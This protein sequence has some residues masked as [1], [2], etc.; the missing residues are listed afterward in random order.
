MPL[1]KEN[2]RYTYADYST[3][4]DGGRWELIDGIA[5]AMAP[6]PG[7]GHQ[8]ISVRLSWQ[9]QSFLN[10]KPCRLFTAPFDVRLNATDEDDTVVLPD[11]SVICDR[12][13]ID[14]KGCKGAPD[15][16][17]EILSPSSARMDKLLKYNK[18]QQAGVREYWIID[19][20]T[21]TVQ[22]SILENGRY[23]T[24]VY[25]EEDAAPVAVLPGCE[26]ILK[27]VFAEL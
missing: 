24:T 12:N 2:E 14:D 3:W 15:L 27:D 17:I 16:V 22:V 5:Y 6:A 25:G 23:Y 11:L 13:K 9:L 1:T 21:A 20:D 18:Y 4:N 7:S 26:I 19:P 10:G 8:G